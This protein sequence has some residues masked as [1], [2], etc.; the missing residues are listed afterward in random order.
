MNRSLAHVY[1]W[2]LGVQRDIGFNVIADAAYVAMPP[3]TSS[4]CRHQRNPYGS[5]Y[6][7]SSLDPSNV[8]GGQAQP[9]PDDFLRPFKG[10]GRIQH[11]NSPGIRLPLAAVL[12]KSPAIVRRVSVGAAYTYQ[13]SNKTLERW[14]HSSKTIMHGTTHRTAGGPHTLVLNSR[15]NLRT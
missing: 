2:S 9:L 3:E 10:F 1:N 13:M 8:V 11:A 12:G 5:A 15:T 4:D 6:R 7:P 14:I